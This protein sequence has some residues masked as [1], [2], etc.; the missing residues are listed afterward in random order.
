MLD[1]GYWILDTGY[2]ILDAGYWILKIRYAPYLIQHRPGFALGYAVASQTSIQHP[3]SS[4]QNNAYDKIS[5]V[6]STSR[7]I[8]SDSSLIFAN[9]FSSLMCEMKLTRIF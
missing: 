6:F 2:S 1:T 5:C 4:I 8:C 7:L 9:F 3:E